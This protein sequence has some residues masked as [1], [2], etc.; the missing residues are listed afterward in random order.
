MCVCQIAP[1]IGEASKS[2]VSLAVSSPTTISRSTVDRVG[3]AVTGGVVSREPGAVHPHLQVHSTS[4]ERAHVI[5]CTQTPF[6]KHRIIQ[7]AG[8][9]R[10][11]SSTET[12]AAHALARC[13]L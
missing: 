7:P 4:G 13:M 8:K 1:F 12:S 9:R 11:F 5:F 10:T 2:V 3:L 6:E